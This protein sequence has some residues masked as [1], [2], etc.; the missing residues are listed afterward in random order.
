MKVK[1]CKEMMVSIQI[2]QQPKALVICLRNLQL[3]YHFY[4]PFAFL[5]PF[6]H[7]HF[8]QGLL[9]TFSSLQICGK[10]NEPKTT[11]K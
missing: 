7:V 4:L 8:C 11:V 5:W 9:I 6:S 1:S 3:Q 10:F 2:I